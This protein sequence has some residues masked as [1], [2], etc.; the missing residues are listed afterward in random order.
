MPVLAPKAIK[1]NTV[2][3]AVLPA[4]IG[5][6]NTMDV[7]PRMP[8]LD[9]IYIYN[10]IAAEYGLRSRLGYREWCTNL[11]GSSGD[12]VRTIVPFSGNAKNGV[13]DKLFATTNEGIWDV[14]ASSATPPQV[15]TFANTFLDAGRGIS[16]VA[17]TAGGRFLVY[18]DEENGLYVYTPISA[19]WTQVAAGVTELWAPTTTYLVGDQ[20][21]NGGNVYVVTIAGVSAASGGPSG[22]G[23]GITDGTVTWNFVSAAPTGVIGT[24]LA[25]QQAGLTAD[26]AKFVFCVVWKNRLWFVEKDTSR[27]WYLDVNAIY[28]TATSFDFGVR[29]QKGGPL[30]GLYNWSYDGGS[31]LETLLVGISSAGDIV[32]YHGTDPSSIETFGLRGT[33][34]VG[35]VPS[36]R[37]IATDYGGDVLVT[38]SLGVVPLSKLVVGAAVEDRAIYATAKIANFYSRLVQL[39]R[40]LPGWAIHIHPTDNALMLLV[41]ALAGGP[42][43]PLVMAM[44]TRGWSQYRDLPIMCGESWNGEFYFG[45]NDGRVAWNTDYIDAVPIGGAVLTETS[46]ISPIE[47]SVLTAF[48]NLDNSRV[49][50]V[51]MMRPT[52]LSGSSRPVVKCFARYNYNFVEPIVTSGTP[53]GGWGSAIWDDAEWGAEYTVGQPIQG[54]IGL[55]R[56]VAIAVRGSA[57]SRTTLVSIDVFFEQ[58]GLL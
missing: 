53:S 50:R 33:W 28:G 9:A 35:G 57:T 10:L 44:A 23:T 48:R 26:P 12:G 30:V 25:D 36:G 22:T 11:S 4:P 38:S 37:R 15:V 32:I 29:M 1:R 2:E 45:T 41:P 55:G 54:G 6:F 31:G 39:R 7:G 17:S 8:E 43:E 5:G 51:H 56:D 49:K 42:T 34:S 18:C 58:G 20:I 52:V 16:T 47:W 14:T 27:A 46:T 19:S 3:T 21:V 40:G 13:D 24:S